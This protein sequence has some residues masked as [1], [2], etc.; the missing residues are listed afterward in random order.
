M[1]DF[2]GKLHLDKEVAHLTP[3]ALAALR[4]H[5]WPGN[6]RELEHVVNR[7]VIVCQ[8]S[9]IRAEDVVLEPG[10]GEEGPAEEFVPLEEFERRYIRKVLKK[11][12]WVVKGPRGAATL[13]G[14]YASTLQ[15]RMKKLGIV[16]P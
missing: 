3:E 6:V 9:V 15:S 12:G 7:A 13:L 2:P 5:A 8:G 14:M 4:A 11:T 10:R 16:R 1:L